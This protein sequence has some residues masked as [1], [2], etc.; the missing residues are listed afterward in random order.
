MTDQQK[1]KL[2][3]VIL[4]GVLLY[5]LTRKG[6]GKTIEVGSDFLLEAYRDLITS[7]TMMTYEGMQLHL[8]L[9]KNTYSYDAMKNA[10]QS[11]YGANL[12]ADLKKRLTQA[13]FAD[14]SNMLWD[15]SGQMTS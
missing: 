3:W 14:F 10:Y 11:T 6:N 2:L 4:G 13:Q 9:A 15:T 5:A 8:Y 7:S 1:K 12:T